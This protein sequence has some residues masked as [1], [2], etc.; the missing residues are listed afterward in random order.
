MM[1][2]GIFSAVGV[3]VS[4]AG[5]V[6]LRIWRTVLGKF[7][8]N[9]VSPLR[10][11]TPVLFRERNEYV[12]ARETSSMICLFGEFIFRKFLPNARERTSIKSGVFVVLRRFI[13]GG[14]MAMGE[15]K[16]VGGIASAKTSS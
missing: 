12:P 9:A 7:I 3:G 10:M 2:L 16:M 8:R 14:V 6:G 1:N 4:A 11:S 13:Q 15:L 5:K